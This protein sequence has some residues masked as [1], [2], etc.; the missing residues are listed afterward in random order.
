M[1]VKDIIILALD[2]CHED[3]LASLLRTE[4]PTLTDEQQEKVNS[5][6]RCFN[7]VY[8][9]LSSQYLPI[10]KTETVSATDGKVLYSSLSQKV[11]DVVEVKNAHGRKIKFRKF[12]SYLFALASEVTVSY[13]TLPN[14]LT[15]S[16]EFSC[17]LPERIFA[18]GVAREFFYLQGASDEAE[19]YD[20]RYKDSL[21]VLLGKSKEIK[22]PARGWI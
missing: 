19:I 10:I 9:E 4:N 14:A 11:L 22:M 15:E 16:S 8:E 12:D 13:K 6:T 3:S 5:F 18:Y 20:N 21:L 17:P 1:K 7:L 2:F